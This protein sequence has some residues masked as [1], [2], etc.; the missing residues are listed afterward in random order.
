[1]ES[2]PNTNDIDIEVVADS[3]VN[4]LISLPLTRS[5]SS[6]TLQAVFLEEHSVSAWGLIGT[7]SIEAASSSPADAFSGPLQLQ[8]HELVE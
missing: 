6:V 8:Q 7:A 5:H 2:N 1:M 4:A 3:S